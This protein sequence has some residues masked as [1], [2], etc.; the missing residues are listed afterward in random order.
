MKYKFLVLDA[1]EISRY[2]L[3]INLKDAFPNLFIEQCTNRERLIMDSFRGC[4]YDLII[5]D[6]NFLSDNDELLQNIRKMGYK[7]GIVAITSCADYNSICKLKIRGVDE[8]IV[9]PLKYKLLCEVVYKYCHKNN[10]LSNNYSYLS[11]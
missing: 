6:T 2:I 11:N 8:V 9:K 4:T 1:C 10:Y 7:K 3:Q 5:I